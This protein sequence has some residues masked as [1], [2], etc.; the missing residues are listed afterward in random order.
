MGTA[1]CLNETSGVLLYK[2]GLTLYREPDGNDVHLPEITRA[3][4]QASRRP[5]RTPGRAPA[6]QPPAPAG[7]WWA[8]H[9][10]AAG[11]NSKYAER[12]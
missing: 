11:A 4:L 10:P 1:H 12:A 6:A 7:R 2:V 8:A 5:L 9:R 3:K